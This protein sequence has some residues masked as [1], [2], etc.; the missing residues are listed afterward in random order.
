METL[1]ATKKIT[2]ATVKSFA[3]RN[4]EFL[5]VKN[6]SDFDGMVD[7]VRQNEG[8]TFRIPEGQLDL[9]NSHTWGIGCWFVLGGRDWFSPYN[10]DGWNGLEVSNYC[11]NFVIA[12]RT[13]AK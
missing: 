10:Q 1:T 6:I 2:L 11:G 4:A 7:G 12:V 8:A 9:T 13:G 5:Y 3:K